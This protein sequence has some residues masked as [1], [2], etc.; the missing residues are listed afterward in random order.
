MMIA[1]EGLQAANGLQTLTAQ[2]E[3][4]E[5][6]ELRQLRHLTR[7]ALQRLIFQ[8]ASCP[9]LTDSP[10]GQAL[11]ADLE[12]RIRLTADISDAL[13]GLTRA[14]ESL[15]ERLASLSGSIVRLLAHAGQAIETE[16][17][18]RGT[19]PRG[20]HDGVVRIVHELVGN[21]VKHGMWQRA[22]GHILVQVR[23]D[24]HATL[25]IVSDDGW[26]MV[27]RAPPGDGLS[28]VSVL[29][30]DFGGT[31]RLQ[32]ADGWTIA[33]AELPHGLVTER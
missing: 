12:T 27:D 14:P 16:V 13:F 1:V 24:T 20:L 30:A 19:C 23:A 7:N 5:R 9:G 32:R 17:V 10:A 22:S 26:G 15:Q 3:A 29:A 8:V 4:G 31:A 25:V 6:I 11:A 21:A 33:S 2:D 18:V 28:I